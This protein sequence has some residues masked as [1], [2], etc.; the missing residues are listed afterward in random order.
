VDDSVSIGISIPIR[1]AITVAFP[2]LLFALRFFPPGDLAAVRTRLRR[3]AP[4]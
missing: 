3:L 2:L 4:G 1:V